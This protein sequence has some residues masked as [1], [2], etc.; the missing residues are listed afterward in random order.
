MNS[1]RWFP[2]KALMAP[3]FSIPFLLLALP[4]PAL[5]LIKVGCIGDSITAGVCGSKGGYPTLLQG[6]LGANFQ[7][8]NFGNSGKTMLRY[9]QPGDSAYWNQTTWPA[10]QA[11]NADIYTILL[12]TNDAK[13]GGNSLNWF[14][15]TAANGWQDCSW[16]CVCATAQVLTPLWPAG[17]FCHTPFHTP[18]AHQAGA[19]T[20][21]R[22]ISEPPFP[23]PFPPPTPSHRHLCL[24]N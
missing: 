18:H 24:H 10:A 7:V 2:Q 21:T 22:R 3:Q 4:L 14:P 1:D 8:L 17:A 9:G 11:A 23:L 12:G 5:S 16:V 15:C 6:L 13:N 20:T 19:A